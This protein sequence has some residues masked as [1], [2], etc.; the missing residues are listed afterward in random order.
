MANAVMTMTGSAHDQLQRLPFGAQVAD[1][2]TVIIRDGGVILT[3]A[4]TRQEVAAVNAELDAAFAALA[5]G[6]FAHGEQ[7]HLADFMGH[8]TKRLV[9]CV[10][11]SKTYR[12]RFLA[13]PILAEYVAAMV[14]G[15][16]GR[17][18]LIS[19]HA[20][21]IYPGEAA[22]ALHRDGHT[23]LDM[24]GLY[25]AEGP[26]VLVNTILGLVDVTEEM[27]ATRVIPGSHRWEDFSAPGS[28]AQTVP[29]LLNEG[30]VLLFSG[31]VLHGGGANST[32]DRP[33]RVL[34]SGFAI[35]FFMGEE[36]WPFAIPIEEA[37]TYPAQVQAFLGFRSVSMHGEEPGFLWRLEATPLEEKFGL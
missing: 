3:G 20:I 28:Q 29:A 7:N 8:R 17:H 23:H 18:A 9:H 10:R 34:S 4:L 31:K 19:S 30:D 22:Q 1:V 27:G 16:A 33:R 35:P 5:P 21:E 6:N 37:R 14:P 12:E 24:L 32:S 26:E 36:A 25:N 15:K 11:H 2:M 13:S